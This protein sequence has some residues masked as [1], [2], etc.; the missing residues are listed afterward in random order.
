MFT[1]FFTEREVQNFA[2]A[3]T[4]DTALFGKYF[5]GMLELGIYLPPSQFESWFLS[6]AIG[7]TELS[8]I[9]EASDQTL[10]AISA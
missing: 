1:L 4:S 9:I 2:D 8:K 10:R 3:K 5:K 7:E 6:D